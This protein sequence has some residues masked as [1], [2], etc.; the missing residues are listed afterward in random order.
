MN[1]RRGIGFAAA[2]LTL[3]STLA[4]CGGSSASSSS[5]GG[6]TGTPGVTKDTITF[7]MATPLSGPASSLGTD[8]QK[9]AEVFIKW[10]NDKGGTKGHKWALTVQDS[11]FTAQG[12]VAA[13]KYLIQQKNVFATWG[14]VGSTA[15]AALGTYNA[16]K[17]PFLFPYALAPQ[18]TD[19]GPDV[20]TIVPPSDIQEKAFSNWAA[21]NVTGSHKFGVLA[22]DS[23]DG[24]A[25]AEGF[26]SG[27][28][29]KAVVDSLF[30]P[31]GT[32]NWE[33]QL[34]SLRSKGITDLVLHGSDSWMATILK[35]L[36]QL[37][38]G[39]V[40]M[41]G[42]TGT[43]TPLVFKLAGDNLVNGQNAVSITAPSTDSDVPGVK[44][45]LDAFAKYEPGYKPGTFA[46]H[47]WVGGV[48]IA[49]AIDGISGNITRENLVKS[50]E[51]ISNLDTKGITAPLT[52]SPTQHLGNRSVMV[53]TATDGQWK[54][55]TG[56]LTASS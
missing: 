15:L 36:Q 29:G 52:F 8:G 26:K 11:H 53:V 41:W 3:V 47:S 37:G 28:E 18:M 30:Y 19:P 22:L 33:P 21:S 5:S 16:A 1:H 2:A 6:G 40:H 48:I 46:L 25:A 7:G 54:P 45:F 10:L 17:V 56:F 39:K 27:A 55:S 34:V 24:H 4:A 31:T 38:M 13:S 23:A 20:F 51:S 12:H 43:V 9:G 35:E 49:N 44:E 50:L 42:S 32:T 14:D